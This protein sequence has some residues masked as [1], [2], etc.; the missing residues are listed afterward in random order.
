MVSLPLQSKT[1][2][3]QTVF[4][5]NTLRNSSAIEL[6]SLLNVMT[7]QYDKK[8][9]AIDT[10][11]VE[12]PKFRFTHNFAREREI[13]DRGIDRKKPPMLR[14][15]RMTGVRPAEYFIQRLSWN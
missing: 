4:S 6:T 14:A 9:H 3:H 15:A 1:K 8:V 7:R 10:W 12:M 13:Y 11:L 5:N 2:I